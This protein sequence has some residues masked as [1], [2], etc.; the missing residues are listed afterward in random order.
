MKCLE[1]D[2]S[3]LLI[4]CKNKYKLVMKC[5]DSIISSDPIDL[6]K[7]KAVVSTIVVSLKKCE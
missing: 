3:K 2:E 6:E 1:K 4:L 5:K 7:Y